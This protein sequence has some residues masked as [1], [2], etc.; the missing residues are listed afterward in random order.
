MSDFAG[1]SMD[2]LFTAY[3][4]RARSA[5]PPP[6]HR[7]AHRTRSEPRWRRG[8]T[9]TRRHLRPWP[10]L[11]ACQIKNTCDKLHT[12]VKDQRPAEKAVIRD[13]HARR[14]SPNDYER[15]HT[16]P[17]GPAS[18]CCGGVQSTAPA[19]SSCCGT[20]TQAGR[21]RGAVRES[22]RRRLNIELLVIDLDTCARCVPTGAHL[23]TAIEL[24]APAA[25]ALGIGL[26]LSRDRGADRGGGQGAGSPVVAD[27]SVSTGATSTRTSASQSASRAAIPPITASASTVASGTTATR[28]YSAAPLPFLVETLMDAMLGLNESPPVVHRAAQRAPREPAALLRQQEDQRSLR[29]LLLS[30]GG[31]RC[32]AFVWG[33]TIDEADVRRLP[34]VPRVLPE[35]R[36]R[37]GGRPRARGQARPRASPAAH[38]AR[39]SVRR[40]R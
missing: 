6:A 29:L 34:H 36:L 12:Y 16:A 25:E 37:L 30:G 5:C 22:P 9:G 28:S 32:A 7:H 14:R 23:R 38:T 13:A 27:D 8:G 2:E 15:R 20:S 39:R 40:A 35:R 1:T 4:G 3:F 24:L 26:D 21:G 10:S 17:T 18:S 19:T 11:P 31:A 33:P